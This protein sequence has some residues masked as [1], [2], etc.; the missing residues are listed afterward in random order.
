MDFLDPQKQK[1]HTVRL[2]IGYVLMGLVL[3]LATTILLYRAYGFG[4]DKDG[5]VIQNGLVFMSSKPEDAEVYVNGTR[6]KDNT[7][8]RLVLPGGQYTV[9]LKR[10]GY[11][12]WKRAITVEGGSVGRFHYPFLFPT[13]LTTGMTKQYAANPSLATQSPDHRWLLIQATGPDQFDLY[14]LNAEKLA[15]RLVAMPAEILTPAALTQ[16][17]E[18]IAWADN[19]RHVVLRRTYQKDGQTSK[20]YVLFDRQNPAES[21]N[22]SVAF[23]FTPTRLEL[24]DN[25]FDRYYLFDQNS[26]QLFTASRD[27]PTPRPFLSDVLTFASDE[28]TVLYTTTTDAPAGK[29]LVKLRQG[30]VAYTLRQLPA[31]GTYLLDLARYRNSQLVAVGEQSENRAYVY[32]NPISRL[33]DDPK[34]VL[35]PVQILK[36]NKPALVSFSPNARFVMAE[37]GA[38]FAVY[39]AET[40]K[41]YGYELKTPF[42]LPAA[43]ATWM[44]G[45]H[46]QFVSGGKLVVCDFDG[47]NLQTLSPGRPGAAFFYDNDYRSVYTLN[48]Q[49]ALTNTSLLTPA[50]R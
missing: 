36:V 7:N 23:G 25:K 8:T 45:F 41:G 19:N 28:D 12:T 43:Q 16:D 3:L 24:I 34:A 32:R 18:M 49:N 20:E 40:D 21:Q 48:T 9:E 42:D 5:R 15:P 17:W 38:N 1:A 26:A 47:A 27:D 44:D 37:N 31:G 6:Y 13:K 22:L 29:V 50:D 30:E 14:D 2:A 11:R 35:V 33:E 10:D 39:D 4:L 46:L